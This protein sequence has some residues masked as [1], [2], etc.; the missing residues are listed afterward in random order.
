MVDMHMHSLYSDGDKPL[1]EVLKKCEE[2]H[3]EYISLTD[4]NT[5]RQYEDEAL[6]RNIFT[7]KI[8]MGAEMN[9]TLDSG[10]RIEFLAYNI[11]NPK[12]I[13]DWSDKFFS[14]EILT[15]KFESAKIAALEMCERVGLKYNLDNIKKDI[16]ITDFFIV[17]LFYEIIKYPENIEKLGSYANSFNDFRRI[18]LDNPDSVYYLDEK[19]K[20]PTPKFRDVVD[21][22]HEAGGLVYLAHPF[23]YKFEDT[24][25]FIDELRKEVKLD[26]IECFHPSAESDNR[27][28]ILLDYAKKNNLFIS[29]GSDF[30]GDK[31]PNNDIGIGSG[32]LNIPKEYIEKW[33]E[34]IDLC[35]TKK[36]GTY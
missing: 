24:I 34:V 12:I 22:I 11:K 18:G 20:F 28:N 33:A 5:C 2:K 16:P 26:G 23:E 31:K 8:V 19:K 32:S 4:H 36:Y 7:G 6:R 30:H 1:E 9:A 21:K 3:L 14:K 15:E 29:G 10:K 27:I 17:Y 35:E 13:N 25:G